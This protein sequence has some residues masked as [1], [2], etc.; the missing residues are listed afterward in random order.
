M[1]FDQQTIEDLEFST[2]REWLESYAFSESAKN[3]LNVLSP[4]SRKEDLVIELKKVN[5]LLEIKTEG[6]T[7]PRIEFEELHSE[8]KLLPIKNAS[9]NL[10]GF[11]RIYTA[12]ILVNSLLFF[13]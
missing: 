11:M 1:K 7:F 4:M 12:S 8:I 3:R 5:E 2:I 13:F 9:I 10:E 6:E